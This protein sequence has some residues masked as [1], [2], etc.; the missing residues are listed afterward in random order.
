MP[1]LRKSN[2]IEN[3]VGVGVGVN[4]SEGNEAPSGSNPREPLFLIN[5]INIF[6]SRGQF[7]L[8]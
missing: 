3:R 1:R 8:I 6:N 2:K 4:V 5:Y 7:Q